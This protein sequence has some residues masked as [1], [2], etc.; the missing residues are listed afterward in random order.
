MTQS[1]KSVENEKFWWSE[2][3]SVWGEVTSVWGE[4]TF[5]WGEMTSIMERNDFW[6][7]RS[8]W[9]RNDRNS[10]GL[11]RLELMLINEMFALHKYCNMKSMVAKTWTGT[12]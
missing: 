11:V 7:G 2:V 10:V 1:S 12:T 9:G 5:V 8:D 3:T 4:V 6:L